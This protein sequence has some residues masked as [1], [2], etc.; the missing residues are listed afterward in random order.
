MIAY[1]H[2]PVT[3]RLHRSTD[4]KPYSLW[5]S[6]DGVTLA[7][8]DSTVFATY[9]IRESQEID[10]ALVFDY[11]D[12][13]GLEFR[14]MLFRSNPCLYVSVPEMK[15]GHPLHFEFGAPFR[16]QLWRKGSKSNAS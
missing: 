5:L 4:P 11:S 12:T 15:D 14:R 16:P 8:E 9:R 13:K 10:H 6:A 7:N 3:G 1:Q 2:Q